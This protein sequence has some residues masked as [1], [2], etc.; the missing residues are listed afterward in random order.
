MGWL[1]TVY[2]A[3]NLKKLFKLETGKKL[4]SVFA[5]K[6][7]TWLEGKFPK[8]KKFKS[9]NDMHIWVSDQMHVFFN[10]ELKSN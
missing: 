1:R 4:D 7:L 2:P 6:F 3:D 9:V 10:K 5:R 8:K